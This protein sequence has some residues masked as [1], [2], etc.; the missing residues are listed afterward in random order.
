MPSA[1]CVQQ[2]HTFHF[3]TS[4]DSVTAIALAGRPDD[5]REQLQHC[6]P[7]AKMHRHAA[8]HHAA[9]KA[10]N[11]RWGGSQRTGSALEQSARE[12]CQLRPCDCQLSAAMM[13]MGSLVGTGRTSVPAQA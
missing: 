9:T 4:D 3:P 13:A 11:G 1:A 8:W 2:H 12:D 6:R 5:W 10:F 7:L